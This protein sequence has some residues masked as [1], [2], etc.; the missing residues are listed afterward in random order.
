M[1]SVTTTPIPQLEIVGEPTTTALSTYEIRD[2]LLVFSHGT[3][4]PVTLLTPAEAREAAEL[5]HKAA[6]DFESKLL[7]D[8]GLR[9]FM[10][11]HCGTF[12]LDEEAYIVECQES[13]V[14]GGLRAM[15]PDHHPHA[16]VGNEWGMYEF[17]FRSVARARFV[18]ADSDGRSSRFAE[19]GQSASTG[20]ANATPEPTIEELARNTPCA[21]DG[22]DGERHEDGIDPDQWSHNVLEEHFKEEAVHVII[23]ATPH[24][25]PVYQGYIEYDRSGDVTADELREEASLFADY[26]AWVSRLASMVDSLNNAAVEAEKVSA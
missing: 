1:V 21:F 17:S 22:C 16:A 26:P 2:N 5:L 8:K 9:L 23:V 20:V 10:V 19:V 4:D 6:I 3:S 25:S 14:E 13:G 11:D 24:E 7:A 15:K 18:G 12:Q